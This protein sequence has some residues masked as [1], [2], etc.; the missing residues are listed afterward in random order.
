MTTNDVMIEEIK[1][2]YEACLGWGDSTAWTNCDFIELSGKIQDRT[3]MSISHV[4]LKRVWGR[5]KYESLPATHTLDTL[6]R[7]LGY[8]KWRDFKLKHSNGRSI[9]PGYI[10]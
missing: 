1:K 6:V 7:Y 8:E 3:G 9:Q 10:I 5:V 4:T 2:Q